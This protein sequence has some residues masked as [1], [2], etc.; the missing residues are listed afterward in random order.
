MATNRYTGESR[1]V[2]A[3]G[4]GRI[5]NLVASMVLRFL[6]KSPLLYCSLDHSQFGPFCIAVLAVSLKKGRAIPIWCQ[7][8]ISQAGL[9]KPL[10]AELEAL[11]LA[12]PSNRRLV[13]VM[14]RWFCGKQLF[15]LMY[16]QSWYFICRAKYD[17]RVEVP[18]ENGSVPVG[19]VSREE[20][21]V[22][23]KGMKLRLIIS[24]LRP[25]MKEDE[26]WFLLTNL[27][28]EITYRQILNR[29]AERFEI[30]ECFKD[31][32]WIQR[33]EWQ[34]VRK[35]ETM[36]ALLLF[37]FLGWWIFWS[38]MPP[39]PDRKTHPKHRL[40]WFRSAYELLRRL[41]W[42]PELRFTPLTR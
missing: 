28:P 7:V 39:K 34:H 4:D 13:L 16:R 22:V 5:T 26:P 40:S 33:L 23:Y 14:D 9:M 6:P 20:T 15:E 32:K 17:R 10:L 18:W 38:L 3:L 24:S 21:T 12:F 30:E 27:L 25:G 19:E 37:I 11:A 29:Y 41:S 31:V 2:R 36:R 8:N 42:P 35:P 1:A